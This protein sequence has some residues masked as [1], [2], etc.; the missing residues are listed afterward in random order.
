[1]IC[2]PNQVS[3]I[4]FMNCCF[5]LFTLSDFN[6]LSQ[7]LGL[8]FKEPFY[9]ETIYGIFLQNAETM[10]LVGPSEGNTKSKTVVPVT[11][12]KFGEVLLRVQGGAHHTGIEI[13]EFIVEN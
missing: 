3:I 5:S 12:L 2:F 6:L 7:K 11:S 8:S 9:D 1:M 4:T 10:D 13:Q